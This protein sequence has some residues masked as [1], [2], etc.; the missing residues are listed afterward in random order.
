MLPACSE[1]APRGRCWGLPFHEARW[2]SKKVQS[3]VLVSREVSHLG[4]MLGAVAHHL[5]LR[6][7]TL[8]LSSMMESKSL[9]SLAPYFWF[10]SP[11]MTCSLFFPPQDPHTFLLPLCHHQEQSIRSGTLS[12]PVDLTVWLLSVYLHFREDQNLK[13]GRNAFEG[14]SGTRK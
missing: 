13:Q 7:P 10:F 5:D 4:C 1:E 14:V 9:S 2:A 3:L 11:L 8:D 6:L 12:Y